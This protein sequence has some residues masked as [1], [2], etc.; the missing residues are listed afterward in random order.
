MKRNFRRQSGSG[1]KTSTFCAMGDARA[2]TYIECVC[3]DGS[4]CRG[5]WYNSVVPV[6]GVLSCS[7][8]PDVDEDDVKI[9]T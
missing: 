3:R 1:R 8:C 4:T 5:H 9:V 6:E 7:C 2:G